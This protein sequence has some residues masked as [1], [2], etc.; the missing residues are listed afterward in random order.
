MTI[1][2]FK[3]KPTTVEAVQWTGENEQELREFA[4]N[5]VDAWRPNAFAR[6]GT[7]RGWVDLAVGDWLVKGDHDFY[8]VAPEVMDETYE[9][10][11][12]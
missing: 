6:V 3:R 2:R 5:K 12:G 11:E 9:E 10:V 1:R 8:P 4:G 7:M